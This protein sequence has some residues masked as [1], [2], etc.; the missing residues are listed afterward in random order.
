MKVI[1]LKDVAKIGRRFDVVTVSD[2][3]ALNKLV[4]KNLAQAATPENI[5]RL[6][7][8]ASK[9]QH[10][11][12]VQHG[13]F[14]EMSASMKDTE[15]EIIVEANPEGRL[16][17]ALKAEAVAAAV[18]ASTGFA[19]GAENVVIKTP[20]KTLGQHAVELVSGD[21]HATITLNLINK[22]K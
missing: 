15:L 14:A 2:G 18:A 7:N 13:A 9:M 19:L 3:Y 20:I 16:F 10:D 11:R 12:E 8:L 6:Q 1:L 4:P 22:T 17:Q 21:T 5:K